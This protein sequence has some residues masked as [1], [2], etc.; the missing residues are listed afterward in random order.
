[1][2]EA[3]LDLARSWITGAVLQLVRVVAELG[4]TPS[5]RRSALAPARSRIVVLG[6]GTGDGG[7]DA[8]SF[9][10]AGF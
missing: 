7:S 8:G 3:G 5:T 1:M 2:A 10:A 4:E 6:R 9:R